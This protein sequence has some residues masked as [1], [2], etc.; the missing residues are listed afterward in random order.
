MFSEGDAAPD[1]TATL[2]D[3]SSFNLQKA[4]KDSGV[5][6]TSIPRIVPQDAPHKLV[7]FATPRIV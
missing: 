6:Y 1:F 2:Q 4:L 3:G 5:S 7:I